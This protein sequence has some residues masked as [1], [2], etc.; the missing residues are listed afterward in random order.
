MLCDMWNN[1]G[2]LNT[3]Y[4][5]YWIVNDD[6]VKAK[7]DGAD[8]TFKWQ[9]CYF[10]NHHEDLVIHIQTLHQLCIHLVM[11]EQMKAVA[12]KV[13]LW[14]VTVSLSILAN[15][16]KELNSNLVLSNNEVGGPNVMEDGDTGSYE[17]LTSDAL[18]KEFSKTLEVGDILGA[19]L[20]NCEDLVSDFIINEGLQVGVRTLTVNGD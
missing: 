12:W 4:R 13:L 19:R 20:Q 5:H 15:I 11:Q 3:G 8:D 7:K 16:T 2:G 17:R 14:K 1:M 10:L 6:S 18:E 9:I